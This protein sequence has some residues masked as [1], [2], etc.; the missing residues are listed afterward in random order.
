MFALVDEYIFKKN[1]Q[2]HIYKS[3]NMGIYAQ[4]KMRV[5]TGFF[6]DFIK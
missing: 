1:I 6:Y 2:M 3:I 4:D 5:L